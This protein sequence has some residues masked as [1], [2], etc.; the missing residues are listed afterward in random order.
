MHRSDILKTKKLNKSVCQH[1]ESC[2][3]TVEPG[4]KYRWR[5]GAKLEF[6]TL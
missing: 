4:A 2:E 6:K 3:T 1:L 5:R